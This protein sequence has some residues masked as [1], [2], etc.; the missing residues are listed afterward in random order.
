MNTTSENHRPSTNNTHYDAQPQCQSQCKCE[1]YPKAHPKQNRNQK[2]KQK[3]KRSSL[4]LI[5]TI[6]VLAGGF[7]IVIMIVQLHLHN[8]LHDKHSSLRHHNGND[9]DGISGLVDLNR[10]D[11]H[12]DTNSHG[13]HNNRNNNDN[14]NADLLFHNWSSRLLSTRRV[15]RTSLTPF[16][17]FLL[18]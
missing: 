14:N 4:S 10:N 15:F 17:N 1:V 8:D 9:D 7:C 3:Q 11:D 12:Y 6:M 18:L 16:L 5:E 2:Q 13:N